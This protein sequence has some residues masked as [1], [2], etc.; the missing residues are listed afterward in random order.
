MDQNWSQPLTLNN[1]EIASKVEHTVEA[2][3]GLEVA[4]PPPLP[5]QHAWEGE[6]ISQITNKIGM[7][8]RSLSNKQKGV[9]LLLY[10]PSASKET[11]LVSA[12]SGTKWLIRF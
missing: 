5:C 8:K 1:L 2:L 11:P 6:W 10:M 12:A 9:M 3:H 4:F 7:P